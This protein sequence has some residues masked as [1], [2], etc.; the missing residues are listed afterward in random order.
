[1]NIKKLL[2]R[3][4]FK[5]M[6]IA[7]AAVII[8]I[9]VALFSV[10]N[11]TNNQ[12]IDYITSNG[13]EI[14][15]SPAEIAHIRFPEDF[16]SLYRTYNALAA[17]DGINLESYCGKN[18]TRYSYTVTNHEESASD[19][20]RANVYVYKSKIIAADVSVLSPK[21]TTVPLSDTSRKK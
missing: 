8:A 11:S 18:V 2:N 9:V 3:Y 7:F 15:S 6:F 19:D 20:V 10:D 5:L 14:K 17:V 12:N 4:K 16:T 1:M 21:G 13:W